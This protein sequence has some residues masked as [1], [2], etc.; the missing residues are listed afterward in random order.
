MKKKINNYRWQKQQQAKIEYQ[1]VK[2]VKEAAKKI[3][4]DAAEELDYIK[5]LLSGEDVGNFGP[6]E[7]IEIIDDVYGWVAKSHPWP[8]S[9][10]YTS[11]M[12]FSEILEIH[13]KAKKSL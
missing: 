6:E 8:V 1:K 2:K 10:S 5:K 9:S 3:P 13:S 4:E 7:E 12:S 11:K